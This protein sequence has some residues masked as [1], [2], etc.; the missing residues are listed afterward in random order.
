MESD[1]TKL[2]GLIWRILRHRN[3]FPNLEVEP[4]AAAYLLTVGR[5]PRV[6]DGDSTC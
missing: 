6:G 4:D 3:L 5:S 1:R 2:E